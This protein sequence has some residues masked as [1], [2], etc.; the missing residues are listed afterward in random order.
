MVS[1]S[2][3]LE[4]VQICVDTVNVMGVFSRKVIRVM[5]RV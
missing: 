1:V 2:L 5:R 4:N 3:L